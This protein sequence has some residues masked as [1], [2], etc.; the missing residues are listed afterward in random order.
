M[1]NEKDGFPI[2]A[3]REIKIL[4]Q[5]HHPSIVCLREIVS[6]PIDPENAMNR[7]D[8]YMVFEYMDHD[9]RGLI[10]SNLISL[11]PSQIAHIFKQLLA[12]LQYCHSRDIL[13]RDI[14]GSNLL[15]N[16]K[17][18]VKLADFGLARRYDS[19]EERAYTNQ[20]ITLWYRP[21]ELL[22]GVEVY[23]PEV[24]IWSLGCILGELFFKKPILKG[25]SEMQ[26]LDLTFKLCGTPTTTTWP[27]VHTTPHYNSAMPKKAYP[28][29]IQEQ[30][31]GLMTPDALDLFEKMLSLDPSKRITARLALSHPFVCSNIPAPPLILPSQDCHELYVKNQRKGRAQPVPLVDLTLPPLPVMPPPPPAVP[32]GFA[33]SPMSFRPDLRGPQPPAPVFPPLPMYP[34]SASSFFL[35]RQ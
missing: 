30:F 15:V 1:D 10:D 16:N 5:L 13:H 33:A 35:P 19:E 21:P 20:V 31:K 23:G 7:P 26:Q 6:D 18:E 32:Y 9:L 8:F 24:D 17:G 34:S 28:R 3:I 12:G 29:R 2:T 25:D 14:K 11:E 22:L 27:M 4:K